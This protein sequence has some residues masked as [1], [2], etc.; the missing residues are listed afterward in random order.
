MLP[1][2][3]AQ[4]LLC[5][6]GRLGLALLLVLLGE[7]AQHWADTQKQEGTAV[8]HRVAGR[9]VQVLA[10]GQSCAAPPPLLGQHGLVFTTSG[11]RGTAAGALSVPAARHLPR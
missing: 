3:E 1:G 11:S 6:C 8:D 2:H 7:L 10:F 5:P 4:A 9:R